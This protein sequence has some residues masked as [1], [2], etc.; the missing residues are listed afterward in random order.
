M[1]LCVLDQAGQIHLHQNFQCVPKFFLQAITSYRED[2]V[3][4]AECIFAWTGLRISAP[5]KE[6]RSSSG[7]RCT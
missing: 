3:V 4:A 1:Y 7:T 6:S 2:L 5:K